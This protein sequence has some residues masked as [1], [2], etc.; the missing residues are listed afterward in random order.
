MVPLSAAPFEPSKVAVE[1]KAML[2]DGAPVP[3]PATDVWLTRLPALSKE[4]TR[5]TL[6]AALRSRSW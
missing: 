3:L 2:R 1:S 5:T 6:P 4:L